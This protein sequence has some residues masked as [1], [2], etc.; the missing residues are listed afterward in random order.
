MAKAT[1]GMGF[2]AATKDVMKSGKSEDAAQRII[3]AST[4][5]ASDAA[6]KANS[7]LNKVK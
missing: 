2:K 1:K 5:S 6:K 3:A 4:R 7:N